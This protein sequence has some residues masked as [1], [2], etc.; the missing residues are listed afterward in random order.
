MV[1]EKN[2]TTMRFRFVSAALLAC[3]STSL[4][5][6]GEPSLSEDTEGF[7]STA[8]KPTAKC[9][10]ESGSVTPLVIGLNAEN[11][12]ALQ[13]AA[14][15]GTVVVR[16]ENCEL[17]VLPRC[18][19]PGHYRYVPM[20]PNQKQITI[21]DASQLYQNL[22]LQASNLEQTLRRSGS[23]I[24]VNMRVAGHFVGA[25]SENSAEF[26]GGECARATHTIEAI[27]VGAFELSVKN[28][29]KQRGGEFS[30][31]N[32]DQSVLEGPPNRCNAFIRVMLADAKGKIKT[33]P[34]TEKEGG[35]VVFRVE[36]GG[37]YSSASGKGSGNVG[38]Q[39]IS[40]SGATV[41]LGLSLGYEAFSGFV[42][43]A[44]VVGNIAP[45]QK[46]EMGGESSLE[47]KPM[48]MSLVAGPFV[49]YY[50]SAHEGFNVGVEAGYAHVGMSYTV[51]KGDSANARI[52]AG[53]GASGLIGWDFVLGSGNALGVG[54]RV[55]FALVSNS[56]ENSKEK[57]NV[58]EPSLVLSYSRF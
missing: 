50:P 5:A 41:A 2:G 15:R 32:G 21:D 11:L 34:E 22:P 19:A 7:E 23:P 39:D 25:V 13:T 36:A 29:M 47:K 55:T 17:E 26:L 58:V 35:G 53:F 57:F 24:E 6:H 10:V 56:G 8:S 37:G 46:F 30:S 44:G 4:A 51:D 31:C 12:A 48:L 40:I 1:P 28:E 18:V 38:K 49:H 43:G 20:A 45:S 27:E 16:F 52:G 9:K 33:T 54:A 14:K 42:V 3:F